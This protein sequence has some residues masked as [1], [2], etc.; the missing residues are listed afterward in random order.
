MKALVSLT[1]MMTVV[2]SSMGA[3]ADNDSNALPGR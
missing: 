1:V 2:V 3:A